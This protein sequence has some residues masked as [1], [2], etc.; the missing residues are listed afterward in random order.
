MALASPEGCLKAD[1]NSSVHHSNRVV[2]WQH[3]KDILEHAKN[4]GSSLGLN[5]V[6][7]AAA[8][9]LK[10][11]SWLLPPRGSPGPERN[12]CPYC[13]AETSKANNLSVHEQ[14]S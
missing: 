7:K 5:L 8:A 11:L 1:H 12:C 6:F 14:L 4:L 9:G 13:W 10:K 3:V 2:D